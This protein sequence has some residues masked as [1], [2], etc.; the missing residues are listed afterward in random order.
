MSIFALKIIP[1]PRQK[2]VLNVSVIGLSELQIIF[3]NIDSERWLVVCRSIILVL[4]YRIKKKK[5]MSKKIYCPPSHRDGNFVTSKFSFPH[6]VFKRL[7]LQIC[8]NDSL[9]EKG[10]TVL[11]KYTVHHP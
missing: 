1:R 3:Q 9:F 8:K 7:V 6:S 5:N 4:L 11:I 10:L 2:N